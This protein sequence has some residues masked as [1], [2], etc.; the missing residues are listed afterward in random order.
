MIYGAN[1]YTGEL[2]A[3]RAKELGL[4]PILA[5]R[6]KDKIQSLAKELGF[7]YSIFPLKD[8]GIIAHNL[9][10]ISMVLH[11][12]GPFNETAEKMANACFLAHSH[13]LDITGEIPV[14]E[15]LKS[16]GEKAEKAKILLLPGVGFDIV[17]TDCMALTLKEKLPGAE[18]I[19]LA[20]VSF[21]SLSPGTAKTSLSYFSQGSQIRANGKIETIPNFSLKREIQIGDKKY[22]VYSIGWGDISTAFHTTGIPNIIT[23]TQISPMVVTAFNFIKPVSGILNLRFVQE[24]LKT[25]IGNFI[26]GP[27]ETVRRNGKVLVWGEVKS[28]NGESFEARLETPEA[29]H[30]TVE[31]AIIIAKKVLSGDFKTGYHTPA[32]LYGKNL[33]LEIPGTRFIN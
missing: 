31:S 15:M 11:C 18:E 16:L 7:Q 22:I 30:F 26:K 32:E 5:G 10:G 24:F 20:F 3:R 21:G 33:I 1:G 28:K 23:Y 6:N 27:D 2:I 9:E 14:F 8:A 19:S 12:A 4:K 13:Y 17:P 25:Q 29:Y